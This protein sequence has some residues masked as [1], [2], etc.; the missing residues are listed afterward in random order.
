MSGTWAGPVE[1]PDVA[2]LL[3]GEEHSDFIGVEV[4][5]VAAEGA[6]LLGVEVVVHAVD[7]VERFHPL[8]EHLLLDFVEDLVGFVAPVHA[9][10]IYNTASLV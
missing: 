4:E 7:E 9:V 5:G 1:V 8:S 6:R 10:T 2:D 3:G